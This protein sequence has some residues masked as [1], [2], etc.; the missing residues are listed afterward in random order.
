MQLEARRPSVDQAP[1]GDSAAMARILVAEDDQF[2]REMVQRA[3]A[4]DGHEVV[5]AEDG[6]EALAFYGNGD[7]VD[8]VITDVEM[9]NMSGLALAEAVIEKKPE[10]RIIIMSGLADEL[11]RARALLSPT[12]RMITKPVALEQIRGE[13]GELLS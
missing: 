7:A 3:L 9:P 8:L 1:E 10:Q 4:S 5:T 2:T 12:V 6:S 13:A 11:A